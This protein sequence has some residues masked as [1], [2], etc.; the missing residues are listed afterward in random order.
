[1][2]RSGVQPLTASDNSQILRVETRNGLSASNT[3]LPI[4]FSTDKPDRGSWSG[5]AVPYS[6]P[7]YTQQGLA[8][9]NSTHVLS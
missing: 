2:Q 3:F 8:F 4:D 1:M 9:G 5:T 7:A 6:L